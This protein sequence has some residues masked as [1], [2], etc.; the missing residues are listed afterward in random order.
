MQGEESDRK[1]CCE[2]NSMDE[3]HRRS[4]YLFSISLP[5]PIDKIGNNDSHFNFNIIA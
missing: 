5:L 1:S 3:D 2:I 4:K